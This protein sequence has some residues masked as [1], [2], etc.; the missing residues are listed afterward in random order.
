MNKSS[1]K[2]RN[3]KNKLLVLGGVMVI[4]IG[5]IYLLGVYVQNLNKVHGNLGRAA[6]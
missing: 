2:K 5:T 6:R 3:M 4:A 1:G